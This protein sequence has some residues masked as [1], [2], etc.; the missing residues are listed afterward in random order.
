MWSG[1]GG[2]LGWVEKLREEASREGKWECAGGRLK[3]GW[4]RR[5]GR[6]RWEWVEK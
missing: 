5:D 3:N 6:E 4:K 2:V 1:V